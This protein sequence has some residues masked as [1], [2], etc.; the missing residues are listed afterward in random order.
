MDPL[1]IEAIYESQ[2]LYQEMRLGKLGR[3]PLYPKKKPIPYSR[4]FLFYVEF[5]KC[6]KI[7]LYRFGRHH[8]F[9]K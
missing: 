4:L 9:W 5:F 7:Y 6:I 1:L 3:P 8:K 2:R